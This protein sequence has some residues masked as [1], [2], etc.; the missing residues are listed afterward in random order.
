MLFNKNKKIEKVDIIN[1]KYE[2]IEKLN[3]INSYNKETPNYD[4]SIKNM[5][6]EFRLSPNGELIIIGRLDCNYLCWLSL[7]TIKDKDTNEEIFNY[8]ANNTQHLISN[9]YKVLN[10]KYEEM[11]TWFT[12]IIKKRILKIRSGRHHSDIILAKL[13]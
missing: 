2:K 11:R 3:M 9:E 12:G 1:S 7:T 5:A 4:V 13:Q 10:N 6:I 8:L